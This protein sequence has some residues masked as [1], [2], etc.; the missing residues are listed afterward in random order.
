MKETTMANNKCIETEPQKVSITNDDL[1]MLLSESDNKLDLLNTSLHK[2]ILQTRDRINSSTEENL[3]YSS[4]PIISIR[5]EVFNAIKDIDDLITCNDDISIS[6][7]DRNKFNSDICIKIPPLLEKYKPKTYI[8][9]FIPL[10]LKKLEDS[11]LVKNKV[12][13]KIETIGMYINITLSDEYQLKTVEN[14]FEKGYKYWENNLNKWKKVLL[15]YSSPNAAKHLHAWHIRSTIIWEILSNLYRQNGYITH[16]INH[17]N[18]RWGFWYLIEWYNRRKDKIPTCETKND[19]LFFIYSMYRKWEKIYKNEDE[20]NKLTQKDKEELSKYYWDFDSYDEFKK[21]FS[22]FIANW[23]K[24]FSSLES[25]WD[26]IEIWKKMVDRSME[27]FNKFYDSLNIHLDYCIWE[28]FYVNIWKRLI[29]WLLEK[30]IAV[31]YTDDLAKKDISI[32]EK[33]LL[34][35]EI[36]QEIFDR[37]KAAILKDVNSYV[38]P[39]D[40]IWRFV[41]MKLDGSSIY[42]TRDLWAIAYRVLN[43]APDKIV[44]EVWQEQEDHFTKLFASAKKM[45]ISGVEFEHV[46]HGFYIDADSGKKLSSRDWASNIQN[47]IKETIKYFKN[48]YINSEL[49]EEEINKISEQLA[50]WSIIIND[51]KADRKAAVKIDNNIETAC[52]WFEE[53]WWAYLLYTVVRANS[54]LKKIWDTKIEKAQEPLNKIEK[55][56]INEMNRFPLVIKEALEKNNPSV[57][58]EFMLNLCQH[59]NNYYNT[60]RVLKNGIAIESKVNITKA[61]VTVLTNWLRICNVSVPDKM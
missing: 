57:L 32:L 35:K 25:G 24:I 61:F 48:K 34:N 10:I 43:F 1:L 12:F 20:Y 2:K 36:T 9:E 16:R 13:E 14:V 45:G 38:I 27:D 50:I 26:E 8:T 37:E 52:K 33:K 18:D 42:A 58:V 21:I 41:I 29:K 53:S 56:L 15:D 23:N 40:G 19:M 46:D 60:N 7:I 11:S 49:S 51:I 22:D 54:I 55:I 28:S 17:V 6:F 59:Y 44:Y 4:Y 30:W 31:L 47:L 5:N 39:L 3:D